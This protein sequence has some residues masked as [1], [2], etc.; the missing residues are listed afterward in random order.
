[1][2]RKI[3]NFVQTN[4][5]VTQ[6][7]GY[8]IMMKLIDTHSHIYED[9]FKED[10]DDAIIRLEQQHIYKVLL[11]NVDSGTIEKM[12]SLEQKRPDLFHAMIGVHPT[13]I[14][15]N[16]R[17][18][19]EAVNNRLSGGKYCALGE[20]GID[21]YW[22]KTF[23][24]E[25]IIAFETQIQWAIEKE[26]P[27]VI[28]SRES[29]NVIYESL[30]KFNRKKLKGVFHSFTGDYETAEKIFSSGDFKLGIN[31]IVTFKNSGLDKVVAHLPLEKMVLETDAPYLAPVPHR[32]KRNESAYL[33][34][35]AR[36]VAEIK[37]EPIEKIA[38]ITTQNALELFSLD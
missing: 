25:Q 9:D 29:F 17:E 31:G 24:N 7:S 4:Y 36:K 20:I 35:V 15:E 18:E 26:L 27:I 30:K 16:C 6:L 1:M 38:K 13:S 12:H 22:D 23:L 14:K 11:P 28:H 21:L 10:I 8:S 5:S 32:G 37:N 3:N 33:S 2:Q 19:L 34:L